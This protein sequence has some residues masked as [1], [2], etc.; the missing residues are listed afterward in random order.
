[1]FSKDELLGILGLLSLTKDNVFF[2]T[3]KERILQELTLLEHDGRVYV[4]IPTRQTLI[5][6]NSPWHSIGTFDSLAQAIE[7]IQERIGPCDNCG[8]IGLVTLCQE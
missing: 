2:Q 7:F 8:R 5:R 6:P 1:M 3:I 4:D